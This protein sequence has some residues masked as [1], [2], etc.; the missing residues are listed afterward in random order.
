MSQ[1]KPSN[2]NAIASYEAV[3]F[4]KGLHQDAVRIERRYE[5]VISVAFVTA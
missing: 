4:E 2:V 3:G 5:N 1:G